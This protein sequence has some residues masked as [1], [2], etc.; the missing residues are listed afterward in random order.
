MARHDFVVVSSGIDRGSIIV[1]IVHDL[2]FRVSGRSSTSK[3]RGT[4]QGAKQTHAPRN[5]TR[6]LVRIIAVRHFAR[7][8]IYGRYGEAGG[9]CRRDPHPD[10]SRLTRSTEAASVHSAT[11]FGHGFDAIAVDSITTAAGRTCAT[12][13]RRPRGHAFVMLLTN[14]RTVDQVDYRIT[15]I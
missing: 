11:T 3:G 6:Q 10:H 8:P 14:G 15:T 1:V 2:F 13:R 4:T 9:N 12:R 7:A 5:T